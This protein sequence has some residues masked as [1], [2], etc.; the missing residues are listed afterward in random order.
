MRNLFPLEES[1]RL[2]RRHLRKVGLSG[3]N[4]RLTGSEVKVSDL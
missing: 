2:D 4:L 3:M 1:C